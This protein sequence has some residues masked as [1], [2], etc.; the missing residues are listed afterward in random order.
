MRIL[1]YK[2][3]DIVIAIVIG[4]IIV[5]L[6]YGYKIHC[7]KRE[8]FN[9]GCQ[10]GQSWF[11]HGGLSGTGVHYVRPPTAGPP[12]TV[13][14]AVKAGPPPAS[15]PPASGPPASGPP[16]SGPPASGPPTSGVCWES[17]AEQENINASYQHTNYS[18]CAKYKVTHWD[19]TGVYVNHADFN[20]FITPSGSLT[21][22]G[23]YGLK[24]NASNDN[25][26]IVSNGGLQEAEGCLN[27]PLMND[28]GMSESPF[29]CKSKTG[30]SNDRCHEYGRNT[31]INVSNTNGYQCY[32]NDSPNDNDISDAQ[33]MNFYKMTEAANRL[34]SHSPT[35]LDLDNENQYLCRVPFSNSR[36]LLEKKCNWPRTTNTF[37]L[38]KNASYTEPNL[39]CSSG[40]ANF[41]Q[42]ANDN[43]QFNPQ[44]ART[45]ISGIY[46]SNF[47]CSDVCGST[48]SVP[49]NL[50]SNDIDGTGNRVIS[51]SLQVRADYL[52]TWMS[53]YIAEKNNIFNK[54]LGANKADLK[55]KF[56]IP[57]TAGIVTQSTTPPYTY[58]DYLS[59]DTI[60]G[61]TNNPSVN[62]HYY[63]KIST[64][65]NIPQTNDINN[66][67]FNDNGQRNLTSNS[68]NRLRNISFTHLAYSRPSSPPDYYFIKKIQGI[69][70]TPIYDL[71][72]MI[73]VSGTLAN[74]PNKK[75][76]RFLFQTFLTH[77]H[78]YRIFS[79]SGTP[80]ECISDLSDTVKFKVSVTIPSTT[81][82]GDGDDHIFIINN[83]K[84][85]NS[86]N[87]GYLLG[88]D[89]RP[90]FIRF[91]K[92][93]TTLKYKISRDEQ[94]IVYNIDFSP[95][96]T[97][98]GLV[99]LFETIKNHFPSGNPIRT[100]GILPD[101]S[102]NDISVIDS[103]SLI[104][105]SPPSTPSTVTSKDIS[106]N[107]YISELG[108][109]YRDNRITNINVYYYLIHLLI[110]YVRQ[111]HIFEEDV[112]M[113]ITSLEELLIYMFG[114]ALDNI[115]S[116][117]SGV[118]N[119][120]NVY[121]NIE[122]TKTAISLIINNQ[123]SK[124]FNIYLIYLI[125]YKSSSD[126][127]YDNALSFM[128]L[129]S[130]LLGDYLRIVQHMK[131]EEYI[132][133]YI[134]QNKL[135]TMGT[136]TISKPVETSF[137]LNIYYILNANPP[138]QTTDFFSAS[139]YMYTL[140]YDDSMRYNAIPLFNNRYVNNNGQKLQQFIM[141]VWY[142]LKY[143]GAVNKFAPIRL[144]GGNYLAADNVGFDFNLIQN[145]NS[146]STLNY[147]T[148]YHLIKDMTQT[149]YP[150]KM[151][152]IV[153]SLSGGGMVSKS[154]LRRRT[155]TRNDLLAQVAAGAG[156]ATQAVYSL[157]VEG[158]I[159]S[160]MGTRSTSDRFIPD[161]SN[162]IKKD[163]IQNPHLI[164]ILLWAD[165]ADERNLLY[166][167]ITRDVYTPGMADITNLAKNS[168]TCPSNQKNQ[169]MNKAIDYLHRA[170]PQ[171]NNT[172][173]FILTR[174]YVGISSYDKRFSAMNKARSSVDEKKILKCLTGNYRCDP[175]EEDTKGDFC[176]NPN[177]LSCQ[178]F[179]NYDYPLKNGRMYD[180]DKYSIP[181]KDTIVGSPSSTTLRDIVDTSCGK[182]IP[183][184]TPTPTPT[185]RMTGRI[186]C[187]A[188]HG[189]ISACDSRDPNRNINHITSDNN[190]PG[191]CPSYKPICGNYVYNT[192]WG[193]C[194]NE[195]PSN[196]ERKYCTL[197]PKQ[198][199][200]MCG[201]NPGYG[202]ANH[203][204]CV[205]QVNTRLGETNVHG[206]ESECCES[207]ET[208]QDSNIKQCCKSGCSF[209]TEGCR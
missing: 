168:G 78:L 99:T 101:L 200:N 47:S 103:A 97:T 171:N 203:G 37:Q 98:N 64:S 96:L 146:N 30:D 46:G 50:V 199:S 138:S 113:G 102:E 53:R 198:T 80:H 59:Y 164:N 207:A 201:Q 145:S 115:K 77:A 10:R 87:V 12:P 152:T 20:R 166:I 193:E 60:S 108:R 19:E 149:E 137:P 177:I 17:E 62:G 56:N 140:V 117:A 29:I 165:P 141:K 93:T 139:T 194:R 75:M 57:D 209:L 28:L 150:S 191:Q 52:K 159:A 204:T 169:I 2:G 158:L 178:W 39:A 41:I 85:L 196:N 36:E 122:K 44:N 163:M 76:P 160:A 148:Y 131:P 124:N 65:E 48:S 206:S 173:M 156:A 79:E 109:N 26:N 5:M 71:N 61:N 162:R 55:G 135:E 35:E 92:G 127:Y 147:K 91:D 195:I 74:F 188:D 83:P 95:G 161:L 7:N 120:T 90:G 58:I 167:N 143:D 6:I 4:I 208:F 43:E 27:V 15:G 51:R 24:S 68:G 132:K 72:S 184:P 153:Q 104:P 22:E 73:N 172:T 23:Y 123:N 42:D 197:I 110:I 182:D 88:N 180:S 133:A 154:E 1:E 89:H 130:L 176:L 107:D 192:A 174:P 33:M 18:T 202:Y 111:V 205:N 49:R 175:T 82:Q 136:A 170:H 155:Q 144:M 94:R 183:P 186:L 8:R 105:P 25:C 106:D 185:P 13:T 134:H 34:C 116:N 126:E 190:N 121:Q 9:V 3:M 38:F 179:K 118:S 14:A 112:I 31:C 67:N 84:L 157:G 128:R 181:M 45:N 114:A 54:F 151:H 69:A 86:G 66:N 187:S 81:D 119:V 125:N 70:N 100:T 16:A 11:D 21:P 40:L 32:Y 63:L 189:N 142:G 129:D